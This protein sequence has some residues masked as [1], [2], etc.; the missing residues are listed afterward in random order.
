MYPVQAYPPNKPHP[1]QAYA[2]PEYPQDI[3]PL[4]TRHRLRRQRRR[5]A[6]TLLTGASIALGIAALRS[7]NASAH[8]PSTH[9]PVTR[10]HTDPVEP[11][12]VAPD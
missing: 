12:N 5:K 7:P 2:A 1:S 3:R 4:I 9:V 8:A 10:T 6:A 11:A